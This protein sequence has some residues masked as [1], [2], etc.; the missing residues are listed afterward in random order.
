M[1]V[2]QFFYNFSQ[3]DKFIHADGHN[4]DILPNHSLFAATVRDEVDMEKLAAAL[5]G[6]VEET[7]QPEKV[8]LW[9]VRE[10]K[11]VKCEA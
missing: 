5:I 11:N 2:Q 10:K 8:S 7:M 4:E 6:V 9:L 3:P 1:F